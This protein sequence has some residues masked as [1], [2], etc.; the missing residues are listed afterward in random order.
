MGWVNS[1]PIFCSLTETIC[2]LA[3]SR[4]YRRHAPPHRQEDLAACRDVTDETGEPIRDPS[5]VAPSSEHRP[6]LNEQVYDPT[7][8]H[9]SSRTAPTQVASPPAEPPATQRALTFDEINEPSQFAPSAPTPVASNKPLPS[10][11]SM[12]DIFVDD[13]LLACQGNHHRRKTVRR[14]VMNAID[15][16]LKSPAD[17]PGAS[18][19]ISGKKLTLGDGSWET[20]KLILGWII[21]ALKHTLE[22][23]E[24]R[25][26]KLIALLLDIIQRKRVTLLAWQ[27]LLGELRFVSPGVAGSRG[28]FSILQVPLAR[29][30]KGRIRITRHIRFILE[31]FLSLIQDLA[32]RPTQLSE[33]IPE[34]P[35][36]I[37]AM[38]ACGY[39]LGGVFF[40]EGHAPRVWRD[41][42]PAP[43]VARL[44]S[45]D[46]PN[47]DITNSDL[48]QA[49]YVAHVDHIAH[50]FD[51]RGIT[52]SN[53]T[54]NTPTL[55]RH[56]KGSTTTDGP[57]AYLCQLSSLHQRYHRYCSEL[58][59]I[60][61]VEN[62]MADD[63]SRLQHLTD[64]QL[65]DHFNSNYPQE[66][67]W[68]IC[69]PRSWT[70]TSVT[71][72]L[73]RRGNFKHM[74]LPPKNMLRL[75]CGG[76]ESFALNSRSQ[77]TW[78]GALT[79]SKSFK[80]TS[81]AS[82]TGTTTPGAKSPSELTPFL[83]TFQPSSRR[84]PSWWT[85]GKLARPSGSPGTTA[86][87]PSNTYSVPSPEGILAQNECGP[88][89]SPS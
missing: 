75:K 11:L 5:G 70:H 6:D 65:L 4:M 46:N 14:I 71:S 19:A 16:V 87:S 86:T 43:L 1:P 59:F 67:P 74:L 50:T 15:K 54:D 88:S 77:S 32:D 3:N 29:K 7:D 81:S 10:P 52:I 37:G 63:A 56:V 9:T 25:Q 85:R 89:T 8:T 2:D 69:P 41:P 17:L 42:V 53:L 84:T 35:M 44:V 21:D 51:V 60:N 39:G 22:L 72:A 12:A 49:A 76:G 47:G 30:H 18:E 68:T 64:A 38:D 31:T 48:E 61:G 20:R 62:V 82:A 80:S 24:R 23:P 33:I 83:N 58:S 36:V 66:L 55:A 57:A 28:L 73:R 45:T 34:K 79:P 27:K 40:A 26:K 78:P 13:F